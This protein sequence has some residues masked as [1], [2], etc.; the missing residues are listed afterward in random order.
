MIVSINKAFFIYYDNLMA[1]VSYYVNAKF[2]LEYEFEF[3]SE[4]DL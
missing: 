3:Y 4:K 2:D 1:R